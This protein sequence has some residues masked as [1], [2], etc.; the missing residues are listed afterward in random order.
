VRGKKL[1]GVPKGTRGILRLS[2]P[3]GGPTSQRALKE[4]GDQALYSLSDPAEAPNHRV[5]SPGCYPYPKLRKKKLQLKKD[6]GGCCS[7]RAQTR[8]R[9]GGKALSSGGNHAKSYGPPG[10]GEGFSPRCL[11][12]PLKTWWRKHIVHRRLE[13][14]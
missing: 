14:P 8:K 11:K 3:T 6:Q 10:E 1:P 13:K 4:S 7:L 12:G 5:E 9:G 2:D